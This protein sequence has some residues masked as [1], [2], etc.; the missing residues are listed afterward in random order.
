MTTTVEQFI[1][2]RKNE[3][4][5]WF[6]DRR[7]Y[8]QNCTYLYGGVTEQSL[9]KRK[10]QHVNKNEPTSCDASWE[11]DDVIEGT[12]EIN[13]SVNIETWIYIIATIEQH[14]INKLKAPEYVAKCK[15]AKSVKTGKVLQTGGRGIQPNIGDHYHVYLF[16]KHPPQFF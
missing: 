2:D 9:K 5:D 10:D 11:M 15:N 13:D 12:I 8:L 14:L 1:T 6:N 4:D 3:I 7:S 16:Y